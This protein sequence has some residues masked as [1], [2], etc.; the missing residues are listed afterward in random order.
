MILGIIRDGLEKPKITSSVRQRS[1]L[2]KLLVS[3]LG[4]SEQF[5]IRSVLVN[6]LM[7]ED[8]MLTVTA[9]LTPEAERSLEALKKFVG[10]ALGCRLVHLE[11]N[12][13]KAEEAVARIARAIRDH[14]SEEVIVNLSGGMRALIIETIAA[15][16]LSHT[17][18]KIEVELENFK[19][20]IILPSSV[21]TPL[22]LDPLALKILSIIELLE[23]A[24]FTQLY[25]SLHRKTPKSTLYI[26]LRQLEEHSLVEVIGGRKRNRQ[27]RV[28]RLGRLLLEA[29][30][31]G[32]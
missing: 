14:R 4:F 21:L 18:A 7:E 29:S 17:K 24:S 27:L 11:V 23:I 8:T 1:G 19:G 26:K 6:R 13:L 12:P 32:S 3:T 30:K 31:G 2:A 25:E 28:T 16:A 10:E 22:E 15:L 20:K 5:T 9:Q